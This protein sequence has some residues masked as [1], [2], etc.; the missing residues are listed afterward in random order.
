MNEKI[1]LVDEDKIISDDKEVAET[2][3]K[4]FLD[5]VKLL[6]IQGYNIVLFLM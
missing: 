1:T 2:L 6:D 4:F 3:N 5:A